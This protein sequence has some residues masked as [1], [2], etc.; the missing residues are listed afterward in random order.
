MLL[1]FCC[2]PASLGKEVLGLELMPLAATVNLGVASI[3]LQNH[4]KFWE[5]CFR[6][7]LGIS[8]A[9]WLYFCQFLTFCN[10][11]LTETLQ[12]PSSPAKISPFLWCLSR[13]PKTA[14]KKHSPIFSYY[15]FYWQMHLPS[16]LHNSKWD[17]NF[18][19]LYSSL[20]IAQ[21]FAHSSIW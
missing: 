10:S 15:T 16:Q 18:L 7:N 12:N 14:P 8:Q 1:N 6:I 20:H 4:L 2:C 17:A 9:L 13:L 11:S 19:L 5:S 21:C 3:N